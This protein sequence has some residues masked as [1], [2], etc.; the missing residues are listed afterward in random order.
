LVFNR[1]GTPWIKDNGKKYQKIE[2]TVLGS[3]NVNEAIVK[4]D[5]DVLRRLPITGPLARLVVSFRFCVF[6][7]EIVRERI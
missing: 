3:G 1:K 2:L 5:L 4:S 6:R 7:F